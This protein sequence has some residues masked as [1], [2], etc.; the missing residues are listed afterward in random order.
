MEGMLAE[1]GFLQEVG[2]GNAFLDAAPN[3]SLNFLLCLAADFLLQKVSEHR[4]N[5]P[6]RF[7]LRGVGTVAVV[8]PGARESPRRVAQQLGYCQGRC[9]GSR[10][11]RT[12]R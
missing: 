2:E 5:Q 8:Q 1:P 9:T 10:A 6:G 7:L 12:S 3:E 4:G 11:R